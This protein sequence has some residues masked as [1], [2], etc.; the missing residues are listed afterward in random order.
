M[1]LKI[2]L[3]P[4]EK[5]VVNG[6]VIANGDR[7]AHLHF[8]ND[9]RLL[10]EKDIMVEENVKS[11]EDFLY[12]LT[13]LIYIDPEHTERYRLQLGKIGEMIKGANPDH[14]ETVDGILA[15]LDD[16]HIYEAMR[17]CRKVFGDIHT[18]GSVQKGGKTPPEPAK[19]TAEG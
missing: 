15:K 8:L 19:R 5:I 16:G 3:K 14:G 7:T 12:F 17:D 4:Q 11:D 1:A 6:A 13:Q 9:A 10:R 18:K 2:S